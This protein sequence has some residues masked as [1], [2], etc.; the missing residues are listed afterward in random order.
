MS[1]RQKCPEC[2]E[3]IQ[4]E[5]IKCKHCGSAVKAEKKK[6]VLGWLILILVVLYLIAQGRASNNE[7]SASSG[8]K[9]IL[10]VNDKV[11]V[12]DGGKQLTGYVEGGNS[13]AYMFGGKGH[14]VE[15]PDS[16][17]VI[18]GEKGKIVRVGCQQETP[19]MKYYTDGTQKVVGYS[20]VGEK[21]YTVK[22]DRGIEARILDG[23]LRKE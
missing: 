5:A 22:L 23:G 13:V 20:C 17:K 15:I 11:I 3:K 1:T 16:E 2:A 9:A 10:S 14:M 8:V 12:V 21:T 18:N 4:D 6:S 7:N 19:Q